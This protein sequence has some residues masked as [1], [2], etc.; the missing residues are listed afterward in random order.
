VHD[1]DELILSVLCGASSSPRRAT[2][3]LACW[4]SQTAGC[5]TG[6]CNPTANGVYERSVTKNN[7][8]RH[9]SSCEIKLADY[10]CLGNLGRF[11]LR[12]DAASEGVA[13]TRAQRLK[14]QWVELQIARSGKSLIWPRIPCECIGYAFHILILQNFI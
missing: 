8:Q 9:A 4:H 1:F 5:T 10:E 13:Q 12:I 6:T 11:T 14:V 7:S 3:S 2:G